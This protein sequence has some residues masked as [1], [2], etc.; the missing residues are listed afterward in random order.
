ME[1]RIVNMED[2]MVRHVVE[3]PGVRHAQIPA[4]RQ[5]ARPPDHRRRH[6]REPFAGKTV[7]DAHCLGFHGLPLD[8]PCG[9]CKLRF[10]SAAGRDVV[11]RMKVRARGTGLHNAARKSA[12]K[13]ATSASDVAQEHMSR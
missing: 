7:R 8:S 11:S 1:D 2:L 9:S 13:A 5:S 12:R 10:A 4:D 6:D 3:P